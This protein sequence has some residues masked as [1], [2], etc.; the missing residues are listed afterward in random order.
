MKQYKQYVFRISSHLDFRVRNIG[1]VTLEIIDV[2]QKAVEIGI[3][4]DV[5]KKLM[6]WAR[7]APIGAEKVVKGPIMDQS[8]EYHIVTL[9]CRD[10]GPNWMVPKKKRGRKKHG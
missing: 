4:G 8:D 7:T 3:K 6:D 9:I 2:L 5:A 1:I 10:P